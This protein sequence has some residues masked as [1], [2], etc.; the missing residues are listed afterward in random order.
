MDMAESRYI[1][2]LAYDFWCITSLDVFRL[3]IPHYFPVYI[4][5][6]WIYMYD[7]LAGAGSTCTFAFSLLRG[8]SIV[9][10]SWW[11]YK[12]NIYLG[13]ILESEYKYMNMPNFK[14]KGR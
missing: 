5:S 3:S 11:N 13:Q 6:T 12:D 1:C 10:V 2:V 9:D 7:R 14:V 4:L 8:L